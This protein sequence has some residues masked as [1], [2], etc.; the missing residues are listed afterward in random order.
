MRKHIPP[1]LRILSYLLILSTLVACSSLPW[2]IFPTRIDA[3]ILASYEINP[4]ANG[5]PSPLVVR[6]YEL[7]SKTVFEEAD[8]FKLYDEEA[9]TLGGDLLTREEF[10]VSPGESREFEHKAHDDTHYLGVIAAYR[11]IQSAHWRTSAELELNS[12][13]KLVINIGKQNLTIN[14]K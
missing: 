3:Q 6:I 7:K 9:A 5:R 11:N 14:R 4:D 8:F 1:K 2:P 13:N 12:K 10:E